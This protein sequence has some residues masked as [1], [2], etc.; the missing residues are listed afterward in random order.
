MRIGLAQMDI[1]WED[2]KVNLLKVKSLAK[3]S[4]EKNIDLLLFPEMSLTGFSMNIDMISEYKDNAHTTE[5]IENIRK[6]AKNNEINIGFGYVEGNKT[7]NKKAFNKYAIAGSDGRILTDYAKI[8]PFSY[9]AESLFYTGGDSIKY[10]KIKEFTV[11]SFI[12][13]DLRFPEIFQ[14]ASQNAGLIT[15][16]ANWPSVRIEHWL[17]L[18]KARAIENQCYIAAVNRCGMGNGLKYNGNSL[19]ISPQGEILNNLSEEEEIISADIDYCQVEQYRK[20]FPLK[21]DRR[22]DLYKTYF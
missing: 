13:Y 8:H 6:I 15:I 18:C 22:Q 5:T 17:T 12:C 3:M 16:A 20:E 7:N 14:K 10:C 21:A 1:V 2:K 19:I 4:K 9:G 11:S